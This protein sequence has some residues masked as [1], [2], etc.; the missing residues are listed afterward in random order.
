MTPLHFATA[1][2]HLEAVEFLLDHLADINSKDSSGST[3][4]HIAAQHGNILLTEKLLQYGA[5]TKAKN[6]NDKTPLNIATEFG[7][8]SVEHFFIN[9][10]TK[11]DK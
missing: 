4:L 2:V 10:E 9:F 6:I 7:H 3:P 8:K 11:T 5:D 1:N